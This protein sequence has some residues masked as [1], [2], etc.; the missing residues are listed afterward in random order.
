M[1]SDVHIRLSEEPFRILV[2]EVIDYAIFLLDPEGIVLSWNS[3]AERLK[4]Y[5]MEEVIGKHF[6][7]FYPEEDARLGKPGE[8][9]RTAARQGRFEDEGYRVRKDGTAFRASVIITALHDEEGSVRGFAKVV[10][11]VTAGFTSAERALERSEEVLRAAI[12]AT[13]LGTWDWDLA[14][15]EL[16]L[17]DLGRKAFGLG[18]SEPVSYARL[19]ALIHPE[20]RG[21][22][23][24]AVRGAQDPSS[25]GAYDVEFRVL[26]SD[27]ALRWLHS[28]GRVRFKTTDRAQEAR[29]F[30]GTVSDITAR[31]GA[32]QERERLLHELSQ[33]VGARDDFVAVLSH[34]LRNPINTIY[35]GSSILISQL[36]SAMVGQRKHA[37]T[38]HRAAQRAAGMIDDLLQEITLEAGA[39][40]LSLE[41]HDP[42]AILDEVCAMFGPGAG[43]R[44]LSLT[45]EV[46]GDPKP[47]LCDRDYVFRVFGNLVGNA[48]KFTP[49]GGA[50][51]I[52]TEPAREA[53]RFSV[54]DN[55]PGIPAEQLSRLFQRG[56]RGQRLGGLGL[57]LAIAKGIVEAHGGEVGV[58]SV[59]GT[60]TTFWFT[61]P[62]AS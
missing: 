60:G 43:E 22:V 45:A 18:E 16:H 48:K 41:P 44:Q 50:I 4:G 28:R 51:W 20:D 58:E 52:R 56:F 17:S 55:G 6:S 38:I 32:E 21:S 10:R 34:D 59:V 39:L 36:P 33:A 7:I 24:Q 23:D 25:A 2:N 12:E 31:K 11:D 42:R 53:V 49:A 9:L 8:G 61:I 47:V 5:R 29:R 14:S 15:N 62:V 27:G 37:D 54:S 1:S 30:I 57:G 35:V 40:A 46:S 26:G 13:G 19:L 3:G